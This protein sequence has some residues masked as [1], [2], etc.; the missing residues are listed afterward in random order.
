MQIRTNHLLGRLLTPQRAERLEMAHFASGAQAKRFET[1]FR[2]YLV[3]GLIDGPELAQEVA[4]LEGFEAEWEARD[5][6]VGFVHP[7][8]ALKIA[9]PH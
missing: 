6:A 2:S 3:P 4:K 9:N 5:T 7:Q 8:N 1:E